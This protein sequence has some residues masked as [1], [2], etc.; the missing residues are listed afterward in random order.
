M[1]EKFT[2]DYPMA[3]VAVTAVILV[4]DYGQNKYLA[5]HGGVIVGYRSK[6]SDAH[7]KT[8]SLPGGFVN[9]GKETTEEAMSREVYEET[10]ITISKHAWQLHEVRSKMGT[11]PRYDQVVNIVYV[12]V[13]TIADLSEMKAGDD[14]EDLLIVDIRENEEYS[15]YAFDHEDILYEVLK[16]RKNVNTRKPKG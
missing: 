16:V 4:S 3:P 6:Y 5:P 15:P 14:L 10:G 9:I 13:L 8:W 11:D 2:Y 12:T 7:P 1:S